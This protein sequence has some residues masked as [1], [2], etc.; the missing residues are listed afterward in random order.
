MTVKDWSR[1]GAEEI[2]LRATCVP[3]GD[4]QA[5]AAALRDA[6]HRRRLSYSRKV[7]IPLTKAA[8]MSAIIA[9]L[10]SGPA[11]RVRPIFRATRCW[12]SRA[13]ARRQVVTKRCLLSATSPNCVTTSLPT[14]LP[15]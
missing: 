5:D 14:R 4:V 13:P 9:L 8:A 12:R 3:L 7:F 6:G 1:A 2:L 10:R 11:R 15:S